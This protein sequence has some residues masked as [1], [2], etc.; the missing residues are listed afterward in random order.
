MIIVCGQVIQ[1]QNTLIEQSCKYSN[2]VMHSSIYTVSDNSNT[3][4]GTKF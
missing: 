2:T 4:T 1:D 3:C